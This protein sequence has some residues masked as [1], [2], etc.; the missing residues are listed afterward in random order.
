MCLFPIRNTNVDSVAYKKGV[1][2]FD[3]GACPECL[4]KMSSRWILRSV[5]ESKSHAHNCMVTLTYDNYVRDSKGNI[6]LDKR[7]LPLEL[8]VDSSRVV[9]K[10]DIQLFIKRLRK[11]FSNSKIK[12]LCCA[13]Y[14]SRTHRA[15]YHL[16]LF[17]VH[18]SDLC[19]Y[20]KSKRG[21]GIYTSSTLTDL[22]SHGI[23]TVDC[24]NIHSSVAAYCTK[25]CAKSRS[26]DTFTLASQGIGFEYLLRY[27]NGLSYVIEGR[28]YPVPRFIW[29]YVISNRYKNVVPFPFDYKYI[30]KSDPRYEL[31]NIYRENYRNLRDGDVQYIR[32]LDYWKTRGAQFDQIKLPRRSRIMLLDDHKLHNYKIAALRALDHTRLTSQF[33]LAPGSRRGFFRLYKLACDD[34]LDFIKRFGLVLPVEH[35]LNLRDCHLPYPSR[36]N[37]A[38]DTK[39]SGSLFEVCDKLDN[40]AY[41]EY[42]DYSI[43]SFDKNF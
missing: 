25:Y 39:C 9:N 8:P 36:H 29:E 32:Y 13:E 4:H 41:Q 38:S 42:Y 15:H 24:I 19:F 31:Q 1:T 43:Y 34:R 10:R 5:M 33:V 21:N 14:G 22:W 11:Y 20:K 26:Y 30:N 23:C 27:F 40:F 28:E 37:T 6:V 12:Y 18:F 2:E 3:C 17:G 16:I 7:G 35:F